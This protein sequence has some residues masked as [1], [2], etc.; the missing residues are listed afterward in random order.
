MEWIKVDKDKSGQLPDGDLWVFNSKTDKVEFLRHDVN[1]T[2]GIYTHYT[3]SDK[4]E[5]PEL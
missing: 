3:V 1:P 4:P 2:T 5:K